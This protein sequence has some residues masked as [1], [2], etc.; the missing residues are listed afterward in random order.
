MFKKVACLAVFCA[1][2]ASHGAYAAQDTGTIAVS[3]TIAASCTITTNPLDFGSLTSTNASNTDV[4][5]TVDVDCT[6]DSPFNIGIDAGANAS[7][8][9]R[10]MA[11]GANTLNYSVYVDGFGLTEFG[12][13]STYLSANNYSSPATGNNGTN[14]VTIYG[15]IPTQS[16]PPSGAYSD[17]LT[18]TVNY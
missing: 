8:A 15:R 18:V 2:V 16:T 13:I 14:T 3:A 7:G 10:R 11:S 17:T 5:T 9:Q 12:P 4:S 6:A 1:A